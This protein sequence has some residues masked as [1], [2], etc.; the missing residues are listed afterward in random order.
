MQ[1]NLAAIKYQQNLSLRDLSAR[2]GV[3]WS[4]IAKIE[5]GERTP[6]V[7]TAYALCHALKYS[8]YDIFP[9]V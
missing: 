7:P 3:S 4:H 2:S 1:N 9:D 8:I 6:T 5:T